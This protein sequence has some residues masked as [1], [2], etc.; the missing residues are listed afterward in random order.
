MALNKGY[1]KIGAVMKNKKVNR[2]LKTVSKLSAEEILPLKK[3]LKDRENQVESSIV[4]EKKTDSIKACPHCGSIRIGGHGTMNGH[5]R[6]KCKEK[7]CGKTFNALT[8]TPL[9]RLRYS[10]LHV[11]NAK[12]MREAL[13]VRD[14]AQRLGINKNTAFLW[15]HR[16]LEEIS[17][18]QP[19][20]LTGIVEADET[21]FKESFKG[22]KDG[23]KKGGV[24]ASFGR[25]AKRRGTPAQKRGLSGE[26][27]PVLVAR[28]RGTGETLSVVIASTKADDIASAIK[29]VLAHD[30]E[31]ISDS[32]S[33]YRTM[34]KKH[35]ISLRVVPRHKKHKTV[36]SLHINNVNAYDSRLKDWMIRFNGVA[37]KNL[38]KYLGWHRL[39][40][41]NKKITSRKFLEK[42]MG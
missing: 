6:F 17:A 30:A 18:I 2:L 23:G 41:A 22:K 21:F 36:G 15:R 10:N 27:I 28:N 35:G 9:A 37:T 3:A 19:Q 4:L 38:P 14:V 20:K 8:N 32:A 7:Q 1:S 16:F 12:Y 42:A 25:Q 11:A 39:I 33:A 34:A 40:D 13:S 24:K 29:P 26:Q 5:K 31:L